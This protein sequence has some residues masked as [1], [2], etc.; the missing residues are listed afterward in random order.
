MGSIDIIQPLSTVNKFWQHQEKNYSERQEPN[1][2][3]PG[4]KQVCYLCAIQIP[5]PLQRDDY[6]DF[7]IFENELA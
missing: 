7:L 6:C 5:P 2:G 1:L 3:L 4:E